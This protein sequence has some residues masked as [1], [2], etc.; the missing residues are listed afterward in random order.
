MTQYSFGIGAAFAVR[1]DL[2]T[3]QPSQF[4]VMKEI[5]CDFNFTVKELTGQFQAPVALARAGLKI[6]GKIKEAQINAHIFNDIFLGQTQSNG[7]TLVALSEPGTPT[8]NTLTVANAGTFVNDLGVVS[9][10]GVRFTR[11]ASS[12]TSKQYSVNES[13]GV[14]TFS[15]ADSNPPVYVSY[16]YTSAGGQT[17]TISN[18]LMGSQPNFS[19]VMSEVYQGKSLNLKLNACVSP[20]MMFGFKSE[21]F[22][23]PEM[24]FQASADAAGN[25]GSIWASE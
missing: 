15:S 7:L 22:M 24:D 8:T 12:P 14:Y 4:A 3:L 18:Q 23:I 16:D 21:D 25:I 13:T 2:T 19:L 6:T 1:T 9:Q 10:A 11:V 20:K 5:S 17:I